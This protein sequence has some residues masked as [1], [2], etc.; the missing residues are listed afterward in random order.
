MT[1]NSS[2]VLTNQAGTISVDLASAN[3]D[4]SLS[5]NNPLIDFAT[6]TED[7]TV[8]GTAVFNVYAFNIG[9]VSNGIT[10]TFTESSSGGVGS[11]Y[12]T[13]RTTFFEKLFFLAFFDKTYKKLYLND[14]DF[15]PVAI[16]SYRAHVGPG[17]K[18]IVDHTLGLMITNTEG[19]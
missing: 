9:F 2:L 1:L 14:T 16:T 6:P 18:N 17:K 3:P 15:I 4:F 19:T 5:I 13:T 12:R 11:L 7:L 8:T 10:L